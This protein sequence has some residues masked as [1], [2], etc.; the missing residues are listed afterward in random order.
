[1][2]GYSLYVKDGVPTYCYNLLGGEKTYVRSTSALAPGRHELALQFQPDGNGGAKVVIRADGAAVAE[3][4][5]PKLT[6][7]MYE[8]SDGFSVGVD[9]GSFVSPETMD[10]PAAPVA[11]VR[12]EYAQA[13]K[14]RG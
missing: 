5:V 7:M 8:A 9:Q 13:P 6:P 4:S 11:L 3:G 2:G 12:F 1:M 14:P 10:A